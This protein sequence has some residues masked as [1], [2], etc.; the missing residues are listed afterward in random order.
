LKLFYFLKDDID[1]LNK[2]LNN[3]FDK[4]V[5]TTQIIE[6]EKK[7]DLELIY[8]NILFNFVNK[9]EEPLYFLA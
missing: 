5:D 9:I 8:E 3:T 6:K 4:L 2:N 7:E 1:D